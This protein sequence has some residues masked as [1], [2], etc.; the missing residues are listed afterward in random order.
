MKSRITSLKGWI[1]ALKL[2]KKQQNAALSG[3]GLID[4]VALGQ[5]LDIMTLE[6]FFSLNDSVIPS[7]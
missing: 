1:L 5:S 6:D 3:Y 2:F 4:V 7:V